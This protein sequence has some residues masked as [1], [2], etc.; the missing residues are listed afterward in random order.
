M[1]RGSRLATGRRPQGANRNGESDV[2]RCL[3]TFALEMLLR[4][5]LHV[6]R[7]TVN[8]GGE[9]Y[10]DFGWQHMGFFVSGILCVEWRVE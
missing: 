4:A 6:C 2:F 5:I 8:R 7:M 9:T 10:L 1:A 3:G